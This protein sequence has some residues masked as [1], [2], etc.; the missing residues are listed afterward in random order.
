MDHL[1]FMF[2]LNIGPETVAHNNLY[3]LGDFK[4]KRKNK[5]TNAGGYVIV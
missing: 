4:S 2:A 5:L 3:Y 1:L